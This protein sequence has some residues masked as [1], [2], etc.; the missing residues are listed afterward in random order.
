MCIPCVIG[1]GSAVSHQALFLGAVA[2]IVPLIVCVMAW[3]IA[4]HWVWKWLTLG[5]ALLA[6]GG[7]L[8]FVMLHF[9]VGIAYAAVNAF[10][11]IAAAGLAANV[12][13]GVLFVLLWMRKALMGGKD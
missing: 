9:G 2:R 13:L 11:P 1:V 12:A 5:T 8:L 6:W 7:V 3:R 4:P 10:A